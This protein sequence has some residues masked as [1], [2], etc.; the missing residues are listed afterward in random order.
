[1]TGTRV[2]CFQQTLWTL[3]LKAPN[4]NGSRRHFNSLP[5]HFGENKAWFFMWI[6]CLAED[7]LK[8]SSYF[9]WKT[10]KKYS[11]MSSAAV[12]IG[13]LRVRII[14]FGWN[15]AWWA[16][17]TCDVGHL[18]TKMI[19]HTSLLLE[20]WISASFKAIQ[21]RMLGR[22]KPRIRDSVGVHTW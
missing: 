7:S 14:H 10:M 5:S 22:F 1:M 20:H 16:G 9:L 15:T 11:W 13:A 2:G 6:L 8:T 12:V 21:S 4:E 18:V 3:T 19:E 17:E